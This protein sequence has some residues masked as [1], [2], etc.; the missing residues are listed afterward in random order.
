MKTT[1]LKFKKFIT[2]CSGIKY[3][4]LQIVSNDFINLG[5]EA[6]DV[7]SFWNANNSKM[8]RLKSIKKLVTNENNLVTKKCGAFTFG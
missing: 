6:G 3:G 8:V 4:K 5:E 7:F 1:R 2:N